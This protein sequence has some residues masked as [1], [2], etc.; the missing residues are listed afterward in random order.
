[1]ATIQGRLVRADDFVA[2]SLEAQAKGIPNGHPD[3]EHCLRMAK[4][5]RESG[6]TGM[7]RVW[8]EVPEAKT[9]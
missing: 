2:E 3:Q 8:E 1:M 9:K 4:L 6:R 5:F 7:I